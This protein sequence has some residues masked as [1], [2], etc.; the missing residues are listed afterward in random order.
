M[1]KSIHDLFGDQIKIMLS[2]RHPKPSMISF[3]KVWKS[4]GQ[5][6]KMRGV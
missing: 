3:A 5:R 1:M 6:E 4:A 2:T